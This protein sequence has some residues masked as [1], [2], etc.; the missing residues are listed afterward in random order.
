MRDATSP[1][2]HGSIDNSSATF[3]N[4]G[5]TQKQTGTN[6]ANNN[7]ANTEHDVITPPLP[8]VPLIPAVTTVDV[9]G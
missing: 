8:T 9:S 4:I 6:N 5:G 1:I 2:N 7:G 3:N